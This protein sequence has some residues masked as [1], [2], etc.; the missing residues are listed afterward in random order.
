M[1]KY[2]YLILTCMLLVSNTLKA[3]TYPEVVFDNSLVGGSYAKSL[4]HYSGGSWVENVRKHLLVSD[5]LFFTPGN[6]L[7]LKYHASVTGNWEADILYSRQ[8]FF[9]QVAK[10]DVLVFKMYVQ[11]ADTKV[12]ELPKVLLK[13][14][15]KQTEPVSLANFIDDF[16]PNMWVNVEI[17]VDKIKGF[18]EGAIR[19]VSFVQ[20]N[21]SAKTHHILLDQIE[22]LPRNPSNVKLSSPAILSEAKAYDKQVLLSWQLPLTPSIRYIKIYRSTDKENFEPVAIRPIQMQSCLDRVPEIDKTYYYKIAWVD[23]DYIESPFSAIKEVKTKKLSDEELLN[24]VQAAHINYFLENFDFNSGMYMPY[25]RKDKAIV[26]V[27]ESGYAAMALIVG[28]ERKFVNRNVVLARFTKMV[29]FLKKVQHKNGVFPEYFDGRTG[30]PEYR[31]HIP[32]YSLTATTAMMEALLIARQYF[33]KEDVAEEKALREN[34]TALWERIDWKVFSSGEHNNVLWDS[35]SPVDSTKRSHILGGFNSSLN[36]Y[37][38]AMSSPTHPVSTDAYT[39]GFGNVHV[40]S[41][42]LP[43]YFSRFVVGEI[44]SADSVTLEESSSDT[45]QT[46]WSR[47]MIRDTVEYGLQTKVPDIGVPLVD[48]YRMFYTLDPRDKKDSL[49]DYNTEV[50]NMIRIAKRRDNEMGVGTAFSD[51]WG[52]YKVKDTVSLTR[53]NPAVGP[54]ALFIDKEIGMKAMKTL[55]EKYADIL[56]TEY[57]FRAWLDLKDN[58]VSDEYLAVNQATVAIM[59]ENSRSGLIWDLYREIPEIKALSDKLFKT[60]K[61]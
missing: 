39:F 41:N 37:L 61:K 32:K 51:V 42:Q 33:F 52:Y 18:E 4:V 28:A 23:Y 54:S 34:I 24:V 27:R 57:G 13:Q 38:L 21:S 56:F 3:D 25:R 11:T 43:T 48:V 20:G 15:F 6:A 35:W 19:S 17:P 10:K 55:Y 29:N 22:F 58:D 50:R 14:G 26:S 1:I 16:E 46:L 53:I 5:T 45:S 49:L 36:T 8:K 60:E 12:E 30:L 44:A 47:S 7:S 31:Q 40:H 9:Y 59:I 2:Y